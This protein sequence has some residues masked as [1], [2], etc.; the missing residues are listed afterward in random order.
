MRVLEKKR[1]DLELGEGRQSHGV[2]D[3]VIWLSAFRGI[4]TITLFLVIASIY[5]IYIYLGRQGN[6]FKWSEKSG[7]KI[8]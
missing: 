7:V 8:N 5:I 2:L 3:F 1:E 6:F 4:K